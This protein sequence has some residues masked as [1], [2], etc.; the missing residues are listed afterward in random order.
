VKER[1]ETRNGRRVTVVE[2]DV[3]GITPE[4]RLARLEAA[5]VELQEREKARDK[6][7]QPTHEL[8][9]SGE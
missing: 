4:E 5:L 9:K 1:E 6:S 3:I 2:S 7:W 8:K